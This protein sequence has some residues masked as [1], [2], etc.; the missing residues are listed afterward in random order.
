MPRLVGIS[1]ILA[2]GSQ[3]IGCTNTGEIS[4]IAVYGGIVG[5]NRVGDSAVKDCRE[6]YNG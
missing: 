6:E 5:N 4:G 2:L 1:G 3:V